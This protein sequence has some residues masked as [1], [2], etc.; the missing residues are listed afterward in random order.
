[1][2]ASAAAAAALLQ[3]YRIYQFIG[4][5]DRLSD[6]LDKVVL[7]IAR[8]TPSLEISLLMIRPI[9]RL[10]LKCMLGGMWGWQGR[11]TQLYATLQSLCAYAV[12]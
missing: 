7:I 10:I 11:S 8:L 1:M 4:K 3:L 6:L 9:S 12:V 2:S 5:A